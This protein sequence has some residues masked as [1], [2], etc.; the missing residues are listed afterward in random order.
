MNIVNWLRVTFSPF[1]KEDLKKKTF[2]FLKY[3]HLIIKKGY[4]GDEKK[5]VFK[6]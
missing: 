2:D 3:I 1:Y 6:A 4:F 5:T